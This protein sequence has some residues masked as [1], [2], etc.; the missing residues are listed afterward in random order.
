MFCGQGG[1]KKLWIY[2]LL[3]YSECTDDD[4]NGRGTT[5]DVN[6]IDGCGKNF[7]YF[8]HHCFFF[9]IKCI[10]KN[11]RKEKYEFIKSKKD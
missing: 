4:C 10:Q 2:F 11:I 6:Y 3:L 5:T 1:F 7:H 8:E 9:S